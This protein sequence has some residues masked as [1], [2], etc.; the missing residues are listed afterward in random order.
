[1]LRHAAHALQTQRPDEAER[2][3]A[4]VMKANRGNAVAAA[5]LGRALTLAFSINPHF[6]DDDH[7]ALVCLSITGRP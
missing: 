7:I 6:C 2:L 4:S 5:I 1:M 3:A